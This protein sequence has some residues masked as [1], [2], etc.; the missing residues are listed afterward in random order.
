MKKEEF[1]IYIFTNKY[2]GGEFHSEVFYQ[3]TKLTAYSDFSW[4]IGT[5][6]VAEANVDKVVDH[7][8]PAPHCPL[9]GQIEKNEKGWNVFKASEKIR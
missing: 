8:A 1:S 7:T 5:I 3:F 9:W 4:G 6:G 2:T